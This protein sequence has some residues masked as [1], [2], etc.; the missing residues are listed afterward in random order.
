M[1]D[2][3][4]YSVPYL[5]LAGILTALSALQLL[6]RRS[7]ALQSIWTLAAM[8]VFFVFFGLRGYVETD[9]INYWPMLQEAPS[10][11]GPW[12]EYVWE[13]HAE[14]GFLLLLVISKSLSASYETLIILN[15]LIDLWLLTKLFNRYLPRHYYAFF[16]LLYVSLFGM[17]MEFNLLRNTKGI[18]L[19]L[20]SLRYARERRLPRYLLLNLAGMLFHWSSVVF[21]PLYFFLDKERPRSFYLK[22]YM[23]AIVLYLVS[24][25]LSH[26]AVRAVSLL[27]GS[28][29]ERA[30]MYLELDEY[31]RSKAMSP[32]DLERILLGL[33]V[34]LSSPRLVEKDRNNV[35]WLNMYMLYLTFCMAG[36]GMEILMNR[37]GN[38]FA[39]SCWFLYIG[40]AR[41]RGRSAA[42]L[43]YLYFVCS[44]PAKLFFQSCGNRFME[45]DNYWLSGK[46]ITFEEREKFYY[47]VYPEK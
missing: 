44:V 10:F 41:C 31:A 16:L 4:G 18:L 26:Y 3:W 20:L 47:T 15:T 36:H 30:S 13:I 29:G 34:V 40:L 27:G 2:F 12:L 1:T 22:W 38:L 8:A 32:G 28:V 43:V 39:A 5:Q 11:K 25:L 45:Y 14:K 46:M 17:L 35:L 33:L 42:L 24:P 23:L 37:A 19:F 7:R 21:L 9:C 6:T